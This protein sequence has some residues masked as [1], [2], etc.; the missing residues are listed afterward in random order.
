MYNN[1]LVYKVVIW[2]FVGISLREEK[3]G[4]NYMEDNLSINYFRYNIQTL[5]Q[6]RIC[7]THSRCKWNLGN[8][9]D[10]DT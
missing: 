6:I 1:K 5:F 10:S 9:K 7:Y 3:V 2:A 8:G 4:L